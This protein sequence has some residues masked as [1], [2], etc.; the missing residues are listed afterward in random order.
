MNDLQR[1]INPDFKVKIIQRQITRNWYN[2]ELYLQRP[3][4]WKSYNLWSIKWWH[5]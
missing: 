2:T 5:F 4:S 1:P 3:T